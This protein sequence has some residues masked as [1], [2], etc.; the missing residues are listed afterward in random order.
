MKTLH[1]QKIIWRWCQLIFRKHSIFK[2]L[3]DD[4]ANW[5]FQYKFVIVSYTSGSWS[6]K[7][8]V[9]PE[10]FNNKIFFSY[11]WVLPSCCFT[12]IVKQLVLFTD[13]VA[14]MSIPWQILVYST[15]S[16]WNTTVWINATTFWWMVI[17]QFPT[18]THFVT[19][20]SDPQQIPVCST[21][22]RWKTTVWTNMAYYTLRPAWS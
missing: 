15:W 1:F 11:W 9:K 12:T 10:S 16:R 4:D 14:Y 3:F 17:F 19:Y 13:F 22:P 2:K 8:F 21:R 6:A 5:F 18:V 20:M 7:S